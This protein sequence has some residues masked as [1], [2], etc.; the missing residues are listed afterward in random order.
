MGTHVKS[1]VELVI[2]TYKKLGLD[3]LPGVPDF[4]DTTESLGQILLFPP[5]VAGWAGGRSWVTPGLLLARGNFVYDTVF[6]NINF[7]PSDRYPENYQIGV[8]AER[9]A[10]GAEPAWHRSFGQAASG[11]AV[12]RVVLCLARQ[13]LRPTHGLLD[14]SVH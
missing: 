5:T 13:L 10:A 2:S 7:L 9:L 12:L 3:V 1:P 4:Y 11:R 8:V 14:A 6:P